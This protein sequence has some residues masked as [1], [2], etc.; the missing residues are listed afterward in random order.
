MVQAFSRTR[1]QDVYRAGGG[2]HAAY[3]ESV[4]AHPRLL[5][6]FSPRHRTLLSIEEAVFRDERQTILCNSRSSPT[7]S[8]GAT[9]F[10]RR[11]SR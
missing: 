2:S 10:R 3:M 8:R 4:Y 9:A 1:H 11:G 6:R 5:R 7:S